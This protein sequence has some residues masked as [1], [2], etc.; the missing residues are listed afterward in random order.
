MPDLTTD[1]IIPIE[2]NGVIWA[3][4]N[5][6]DN[7]QTENASVAEV[8][9]LIN[10]N[11]LGLTNQRDC[12][13]VSPP[14]VDCVKAHHNAFV[15]LVR[16]IDSRAKAD[17]QPRLNFAHITSVKRVFKRYPVRYFDQ[18]NQ[19]TRRWTELYLYGLSSLAQL[20]EANT[21]QN[22]WSIMSAHIMKMPFQEAYRLMCIDLFGVPAENFVVVSGIDEKPQFYLTD[23]DFS[24]YSPS[25]L[26]SSSE[27]LEEPYTNFFTEDSLRSISEIGITPSEEAVQS[28]NQTNGVAAIIQ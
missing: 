6:G 24:T 16:F 10:R 26:I 4:P 2:H 15:R 21:W 12:F 27:Y 14:S 25:S 22:D 9:E 7:T 28:Q 18:K 19:W 1:S 13:V 20:S 17:N 23:A 5:I 11:L 8:F 3:L